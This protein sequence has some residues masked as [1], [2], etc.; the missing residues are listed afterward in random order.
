MTTAPIPDSLSYEAASVLPIGLL[1]AGSALFLPKHLGLP[2][3]SLTPR[4]IEGVVLVLGGSSSV[5]CNAIQLARAAGVEIIAT[6]SK[7]NFDL[8]K[9]LG[10]TQAF[11]RSAPG[12]VGDI[13]AYLKGKKLVGIVNAIG[14]KETVTAAVEIV[15]GSGGSAPVV[16][17]VPIFQELDRKGVS[18]EQGKY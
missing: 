1:T 5:G 3:P 4:P 18:I 15:I 17:S 9:S 14:D 2:A 12:T 6:A 13:L 7:H 10:A 8:V 16:N 11:D